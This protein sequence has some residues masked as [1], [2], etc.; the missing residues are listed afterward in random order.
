MNN[1]ENGQE[2]ANNRDDY[3]MNVNVDSKQP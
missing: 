1:A 3:D 2:D